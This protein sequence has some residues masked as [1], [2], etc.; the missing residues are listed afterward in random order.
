MKNSFIFR[1]WPF[2]QPYRKYV[3]SGFILMCLSTL[4]SLIAPY[5]TI[6]LMNNVLIPLQNQHSVEP[7]LIYYYLLAFL[8]TAILTW[9]LSWAKTFVLAI[10]SECITKH[11]RTYTFNHILTLSLEFYN[12]RRTGD[13]INRIGQDTDRLNIF[14]ATSLLNFIQDVV[15]FFMILAF[16][17]SL[18]TELGICTLLPVPIIFGLILGLK[19]KL[20]FCFEQ[21]SRVWSQVTNHL[22]EVISG[23]RLVKC[24]AQEQ[25][26]M[27]N[28]ENINQRNLKINNHMNKIWSFFSPTNT[29]ITD[30]GVLLIWAIGIKMLWQHSINLGVLTGFIAYSTKLYSRIESISYFFEQ[31]QKTCIYMKRI[32]ELLDRKSKLVE[33]IHPIHLEHI[34][35]RIDIKDLDFSYDDKQVLHH[36]NLSIKPGERIGLVGLSGAGKSSLMNLIC[37]FYDPTAGGIFLDNIN[38]KDF[39]VYDYRNFLGIVLQE[40]FLFYGTIAQNIAYAN[41]HA[42]DQEIMQ[43]AKLA[44]AHEFILRQPL[45]YDT[46]IQEGGSSLSGGEKQRIAI[47]RTIL[48][49]PKIL[50][51]DEPTSALDVITED[52]I[53]TALNHLMKDRTTIVISHRLSSLQSF[54]RL[55][56]IENGRIVEIGS[57]DELMRN[58]SNYYNFYQLHKNLHQEHLS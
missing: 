16:I 43:A 1:L 30:L 20:S 54:D 21:C 13:L 42:T 3:F 39:S 51:L 56:V 12:Y 40:S 34:E 47:A 31:Y 19:N 8:V 11:L 28:F 48:S 52:A 22:T 14:M 41:P 50:L 23:I 29:F 2:V 27:I 4:V 7:T 9:L 44:N 6:G 32:Y 45:G 55:V 10:G 26:E 25:K 49:N 15:M 57:H 38:I 46:L 35:G 17:F 33:T 24:F 53:Q 18:H 37:R 5:L 36:I 58:Q